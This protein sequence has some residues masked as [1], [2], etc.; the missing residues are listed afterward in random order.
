LEQFWHNKTSE[1]NRQVKS[2]ERLHHQ[3]ND[4]DHNDGEER[5]WRSQDPPQLAIKAGNFQARVDDENAYALV[6]VSE[7]DAHACIF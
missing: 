2:L 3:D 7:T 5:A 4:N 1:V 6:A